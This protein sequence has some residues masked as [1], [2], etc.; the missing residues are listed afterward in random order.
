MA[1]E[2]K[3]VIN[4]RFYEQKFPEV[5]E[6][7]MVRVK[8]IT[9]IG[10][11]VSLLE[12]DNSE[13]LILSS[14]L[15]RKRIRSISQLIR[16]GR[17]EA[18]VVL[19]VDS[20]KGYVDLS[21]SKVAPEDIPKCEERYNKAKTVHSI[22]R[23]LAETTN[24]DLEHLY[25][26]VGWPLYRRFTHAF[27][28][29]KA[30]LTEPDDVFKDI[31][32]PTPEIREQLLQIIQRRLKPQP[33]KIRADVEV[34]C[35]SYEGIDAIKKAL[36][37]GEAH[38][39]EETPISIT[40]VAPP[41]YVMVTTSHDKVHGTSVLEKAVK[42]ITESIEESGGSIVIK[43]APRVVNEKD[44]HS[45]SVLLEQL[46]DQNKEVGGDSESEEEVGM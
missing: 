13:G 8:S 16:V 36:K 2:R 19:R 28:A 9:D 35:F 31:A 43:A 21:K 17:T 29:F 6:L 5:D 11:Y 27:D 4:C 44:D 32:F 23:H 34:T 20:E 37:L 10:A 12:Y 33:V 41:L 30:A 45:L 24:Q 7:V 22:M 15:S 38:G 26:V 39:D 18:V 46:K 14:E 3:R 40:L 1:E 25:E 42:T